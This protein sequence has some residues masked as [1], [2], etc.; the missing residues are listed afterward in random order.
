MSL[1][2]T[3]PK[4]DRPAAATS[5]SKWLHFAMQSMK[6]VEKEQSRELIKKA[7]LL[8]GMLKSGYEKKQILADFVLMGG[9]ASN[10]HIALST[11]IDLLIVYRGNNN[12]LF[13][14]DYQNLEAI[15]HFREKTKQYLNELFP[16]AQVDDSLPFALKMSIPSWSCTF[17]L[18]FGFWHINRTPA[19]GISPIDGRVKIYNKTEIDFADVDPLQ[20]MFLLNDKNVKTNENAKP[21]IRILKTLK[22]QSENK[23]HL[24]GFEIASI[25]YSMDEYTLKKQQGLL[26]FLLLECSLFLKRLED[27]VFLQRSIKS[28]DMMELFNLS[29]EAYFKK[30]IK[31]L[32]AELD[33]L[34]KH[35][36]LE[37]DLYTN[38]Y[39][40]PA[41][42]KI[43]L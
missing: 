10:T 16:E 32:K 15:I 20:A 3:I 6:A 30:G 21:L 43:C 18:H 33:M 9:L 11:T 42:M 1:I 31:N 8:E 24:S 22:A 14:E 29:N 13:S 2:Q 28:P 26:L 23:E 27:S 36:V 40:L 19:S 4:Q 5:N 39:N 35:L 38:I 37:I 12:E 25:V 41:D 7:E 34:I 17:C